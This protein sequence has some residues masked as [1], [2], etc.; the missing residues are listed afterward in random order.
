M[1]T[2]SSIYSPTGYGGTNA[3][4]FKPQPINENNP[5]ANF[6]QSSQNLV[7]GEGAKNVQ[8]GG[9]TT[10]SGL[11]AMA[12]VLQYLTKLTM[13]DQADVEQATQPQANQIRDSFQAVRNMISQQPRGGGKAGVLAEAPYKERQQVSDMQSQARQGAA[14]QLGQMASTLAGIG[15]E[16]GQLGEAEQGLAMES[17]LGQRGQNIGQT[18]RSIAEIMGAII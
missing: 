12:P 6:L 17:A 8:S 16:Q 2:N 1:A 7:A 13:G 5:M 4:G 10:Q 3:Y 14:G 18:S 11:G 15:L 9:Q